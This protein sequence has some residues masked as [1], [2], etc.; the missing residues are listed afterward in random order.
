MITTHYIEKTELKDDAVWVQVVSC[1]NSASVSSADK[2]LRAYAETQVRQIIDH[3]N[4]LLS[5]EADRGPV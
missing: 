2:V 3:H 1:R 5:M 4:R